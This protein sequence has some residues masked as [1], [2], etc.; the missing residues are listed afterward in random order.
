MAAIFVLKIYFSEASISEMC[1]SIKKKILFLKYDYKTYSMLHMLGNKKNYYI[2]Y[3]SE[4][5]FM[6]VVYYSYSYYMFI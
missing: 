4:F 6:K 2:A 1:K 3:L 5:D